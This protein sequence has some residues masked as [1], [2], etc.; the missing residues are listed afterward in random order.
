[1]RREIAIVVGLAA[2]AAG[3]AAPAV[4]SDRAAAKSPS[5]SR[6]VLTRVEPAPV[7]PRQARPT[8]QGTISPI[9]PDLV[10]E[11]RG[12]T[13]RP[14]CPIPIR[15]LRLLSLSYWGFDGEVHEGPMVVNGSVAEG[16]VSA[17][18]RL[19]RDHF[20]I[21]HMALAR[22]YRPKQDE[23][24]TKR[25]ITAAFNCRVIVT[26][27]GP[28]TTLSVHSYGLAID[29]NPLQNPYV[30]DDGYVRNRYARPYRDRSQDLPGMIHDGDVVVGAFA[31]IG[32]EWGGNWSGG[33]DYMHFSANG[34]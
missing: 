22:R 20:P 15:D 31:R 19:F 10:A 28:G 33:K 3:C 9:P 1:M 11:M 12:T 21:K 7:E 13:W 34:R 2:L 4:G 17:F 27:A 25:S 8:F 6:M 5:A 23:P 30:A 29:I 18:Q 26:P 32:W 16:V 14:G 24:N